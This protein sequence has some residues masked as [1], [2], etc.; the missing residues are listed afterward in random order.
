MRQETLKLKD[1]VIALGSVLNPKLTFS[2][3]VKA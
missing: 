2:M 1:F 3:N